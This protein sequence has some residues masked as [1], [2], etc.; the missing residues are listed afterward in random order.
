MPGEI[1]CRGRRHSANKKIENPQ[2]LDISDF[3]TQMTEYELTL[4]KVVADLRVQKGK[5]IAT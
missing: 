3:I 4:S 1:C 2:K 5:Q